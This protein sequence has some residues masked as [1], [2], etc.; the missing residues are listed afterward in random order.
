[1]IGR[2][3][4]TNEESEMTRSHTEKA[5][6]YFSATLG[7]IGGLGG[8]FVLG[9]AFVTAGQRASYGAGGACLSSAFVLLV[10]A[11]SL[12]N[13][14]AAARHPAHQAYLRG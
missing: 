7:A 9:I 12:F 4:F 8:A 10:I 2:W 5:L 13:R 14:T 11:A 6:A 3:H 1:M